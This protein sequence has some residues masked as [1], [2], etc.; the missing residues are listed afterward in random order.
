MTKVYPVILTPVKIDGV[1]GYAVYIPGL[2]IDTQGFDLADA[3]Y[4][5]REAIGAKGIC[6]QEN[7]CLIPEPSD[8]LPKAAE[9]EIVTYVD[10]DFDEYR[11]SVDMTAER[12]N[13]TL[14]RYLKRKAE[15]SGINFSQE[16]Q[17]RLKERLRVE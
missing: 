13:V 11:Q 1:G 9:N 8:V 4:M 7:G 6:E 12:T 10:I 3:I 2:E 14:P 15:A 16:L 17:E 5:A